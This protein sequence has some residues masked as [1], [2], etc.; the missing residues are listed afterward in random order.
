VW[1]VVRVVVG[2]AAGPVVGG[3]AG[4]M[5]AVD[6]V[7]A[8]AFV[9]DRLV[10]EAADPHPHSGMASVAHTTQASAP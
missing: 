7:G 8:D 3:P 4:L 2:A 9:L 5:V 6:V 10:D 1:L